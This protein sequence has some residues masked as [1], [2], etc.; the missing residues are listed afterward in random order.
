MARRRG[1]LDATAARPSTRKPG[2]RAQSR[3]REPAVLTCLPSTYNAPVSALERIRLTD[4]LWVRGAAIDRQRNSGSEKRALAACGAPIHALNG[5]DDV[6]GLQKLAEKLHRSDQHVILARL[7]PRELNALYPLFRDRGNF[8]LVVD[9]WWS[10]PHR[11]TRRAS[12]ILYR[13]FNGLAVRRNWN[14]LARTGDAPLFPLPETWSLY[15]AAGCA[16][17]LP[18]LFASPLIAA[19]NVWRRRM[20]PADP[21]RWVYFPFP[22][23]AADVPLT[24]EQVEFDFSNLGGTYG[25]WVIRDP[26]APPTLNFTNLYHDRQL[27][28]D[29]LTRFRDRP[30]KTYDWRWEGRFLRYEEYSSYARRSRF[31]IS[32]GGVH[33]N[34]VP[35][36]L[37]FACLGVPMIGRLLPYEYP[38]L[39]DCLFPIDAQGR[40][41][42]DLRG[43]F[44]D[45]LE[46]YPRYRENCLRWREQLF[47]Q[48]HLEQVLAV[49]QA[50]IDGKPIPP[51]YL[52]EEAQVQL[53][54]GE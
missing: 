20:E 39:K 17:R 5:A 22:I 6:E 44:A 33:H 23:D 9:D 18:V 38:W 29:A 45:A 14:P 48:Y 4:C 36:F 30:F 3:R 51:G 37:E 49:A 24:D 16:L 8:S 28:A 46:Q 40:N 1:E 12:Y 27:L 26:W 35:K 25:I 19:L 15:G 42:T 11:F 34:S 47:R 32:T 10:T 41:A 43:H 53:S 21:R 7:L 52:T 13:N 50:Q 2:R 54:S 31:T